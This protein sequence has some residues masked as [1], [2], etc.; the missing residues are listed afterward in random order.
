MDCAAFMAHD[1]QGARVP[2]MREGLNRYSVSTHF[3]RLLTEYAAAQSIDVEAWLGSCGLDRQV[4]GDPDGRIA[5]LAYARLLDDLAERSRQ[6]HLGL[7]LGP[8]IRVAHLGA[9]GL[10]QMACSTVRELLPRMARYN[11]L[12]MD[13]FEDD[14]Q[15]TD[16]EV[17]LNWRQ[18]IPS[19]VRVSR[20]HAELNF[21]LT[22]ALVPQFTGE[23]IYPS[24]VWFRHPPP[25]DPGRLSDHFRCEVRFDAPVDLLACDVRVLDTELHVPDPATLRLLDRL[26]EQQLKLLEDR[27]QPA[28]LLACKQAITASLEDGQPELSGIA[29]AIGFTERQLRRK[30]G[31]QGLNFRG[32]IDE[33]RQSLA[34][35]YMA[36]DSLSLV[37]VAMLLGFSE[38]S[39]FHRAYRRWT[40]EA[41]GTARR[42]LV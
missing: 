36:D 3:L 12:I 38:Q 35:I 40:G 9:G 7:E 24:R 5:F 34:E 21:A 15:I 10:A 30:L 2:R 22:Q 31:E 6:P 33:R 11:S 13:A 37:D 28:W 20:H 16:E 27:Q 26:C 19:E 4:L 25:A 32:L 42:K 14:L 18:R 39:A 1:G 17:V 8:L 29:A 23:Q 41:P